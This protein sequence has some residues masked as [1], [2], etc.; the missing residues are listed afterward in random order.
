VGGEVPVVTSTG[1]QGPTTINYR[2]IGTSLDS[3]AFQLDGGRFSISLTIEDSSV[4][5]EDQAA[6]PTRVGGQPSFSTFRAIETMIL[7]DGQSAQ[8]TTATDKVTGLV[9]KVDVTLTVLK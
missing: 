9:T 4:Y 8:Y 2:N 3:Q 1:P 5:P 6:S 7:R